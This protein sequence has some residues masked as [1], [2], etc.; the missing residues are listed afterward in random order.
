MVSSTPKEN[1]IICRK[2]YTFASK[3]I[4][5]IVNKYNTLGFNLIDSK[6]M[7]EWM[8]LVFKSE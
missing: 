4:N 7:D 6:Q 3:K 2:Y 8:V 5:N 1:I